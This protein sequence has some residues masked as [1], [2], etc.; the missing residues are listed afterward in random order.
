[1]ISDGSSICV[2]PEY[3]TDGRLLST[4]THA[5]LLSELLYREELWIRELQ[6]YRQISEEDNQKLK[7]I[8][9]A[10]IRALIQQQTS[11][12]SERLN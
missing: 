9:I 4:L 5:E 8:N 11:P 6:R 10:L 1:M 12:Q 7:E 3:C 2:G